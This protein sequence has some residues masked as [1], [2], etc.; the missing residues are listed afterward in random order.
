LPSVKAQD[1]CGICKFV[2]SQIDGYLA[3]NKTD[4]QI[5]TTLDNDCKLLVNTAWITDCQ[6]IVNTYGQELITYIVNTQ[7]PDKACEEIGFCNKT[8]IA[9]PTGALECTLCEYIVKQAEG[10]LAANN[11]EQD[12][13]AFL[14]KDCTILPDKSWVTTCQGLVTTFGPQIINMLINKE[15][16]ATICAQIDLC[17]NSSTAKLPINIKA[18]GAMECTICEFLVG[19]IETY[20]DNNATETVIIDSLVHD[21][22]DLKE[23]TIV[24]ACKNLVS[25]YGAEMITLL[26]NEVPPARVCTSVGV[27]TSTAILS[28]PLKINNKI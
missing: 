10:Y 8:T 5:L 28:K 11:T 19:Q 24:A 15:P 26:V 9:A 1:D 6:N 25:T 7:T 18:G 3:Q 16:P 23:Q 27:C 2:V 4:Q 20:L 21:C 17:S 13:L 22:T 12:I 14:E